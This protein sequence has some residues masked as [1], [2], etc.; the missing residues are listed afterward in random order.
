MPFHLVEP[1]GRDTYRQA[2]VISTHQTLE[3]AYAGL[4]QIA[5][6]LDRDGA[7]EDYLQV[8]VV[9]EAKEPMTRPADVPPHLS[10]TRV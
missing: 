8:H 7:P 5:D 2:T 3:A 1:W 10:R 9:N 6:K 4:N